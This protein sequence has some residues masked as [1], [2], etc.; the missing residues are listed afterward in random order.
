MEPQE[1][2]NE[3]NWANELNKK[4][5]NEVVGPA[6]YVCNYLTNLN[7]DV[8]LN[9][10][11]MTSMIENQEPFF[12]TGNK[13]IVSEYHKKHPVIFALLISVCRRLLPNGHPQKCPSF[14]VL[15]TLWIR[16][17]CR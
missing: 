14:P 3:S 16:F 8:T 2:R 12:G 13:F 6:T 11:L 5:D 1:C 7:E 10:A 9:D 17:L 4:L 15:R